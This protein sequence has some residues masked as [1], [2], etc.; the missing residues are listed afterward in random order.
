M[1]CKGH[2]LPTCL[3]GFAK[4]FSKSKLN[5]HWSERGVVCSEKLPPVQSSQ[6]PGMEKQGLLPQGKSQLRLV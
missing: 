6:I 5:N 1:V 2:R 3:P 4:R